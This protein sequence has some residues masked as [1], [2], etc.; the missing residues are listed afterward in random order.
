MPLYGMMAMLEPLRYNVRKLCTGNYRK[1]I[2]GD[3]CDI[4]SENRAYI[5]RHNL[6]LYSA[7][8]DFKFC[9]IKWGV[10]SSSYK[11]VDTQGAFSN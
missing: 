9:V 5:I 6:V 7:L 11:G 8:R 3:S 1:V 10:S 2:S 4:T